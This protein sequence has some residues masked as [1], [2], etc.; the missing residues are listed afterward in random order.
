MR[1]SVIT[2]TYQRS[3]T[4]LQRTTSHFMASLHHLPLHSGKSSRVV[5]CSNPKINF[6]FQ[7]TANMEVSLS[8]AACDPV[9]SNHGE[10][11]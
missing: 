8:V 3:E 2:L 6:S 7:R 5:G 9:K 1:F 10:T 11:F 4:L